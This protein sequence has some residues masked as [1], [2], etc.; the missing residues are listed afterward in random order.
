VTWTRDK[1]ISSPKFH[2]CEMAEETFVRKNGNMNGIHLLLAVSTSPDKQVCRDATDEYFIPKHA[3]LN[4]DENPCQLSFCVFNVRL[5][6]SVN[7]GIQRSMA[8]FL[9][10]KVLSR[11]MHG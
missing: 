2:P 10:K 5:G 9:E 8:S 1:G 7:L 11:S 6:G 4:R 3:R